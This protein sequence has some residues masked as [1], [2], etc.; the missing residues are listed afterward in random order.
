MRVWLAGVA[1]CL[2][3]CGGADDKGDDTANLGDDLPETIVPTGDEFLVV[4]LPDTQ[5]YAMTYPETFDSQMR[6]IAEHAEAYN[7]VFVSH[8]GDI[9]HNG[10][11]R[12]EWDVAEA[13]YQWIEDIGLPHGFSVGGHDFWV[14]GEEHDSSCA[15]VPWMD[16]DFTDFNESFGPDRYADRA[17][18]GGASPSGRSSYQKV[19][20]AGLDL[21]FLHLPQDTPRAEVEWAG[22]VLDANPGTL[23]HLTTHRYLYDYRLTDLLPEPLNLAPAGRFN[24]LTYTLGGQSLLFNDS[25]SADELFEEFI[26]THPNIWGV[27]CGHV[28]AEF[29]QTETNAAGLPV[30]QMLADFQNMEDGGGGWLR[31]LKFQPADNEVEVFTLST[32]TGE[33]RQ[34]GDGFEHSLTIVEDYKDLAFAELAALGFD[35]QAIED[36]LDEVKTEGSKLRDAYYESLYGAGDRDSRFTLEVPFSDYVDASK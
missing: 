29:R 27:H 10:D 24:A 17:W 13:S 5:I 8:V 25:L 23:V 9:V 35:T 34:N 3:G 36:L 20:S 19:S 14:G 28:D 21:L 16:C 15:V 12:N 4:V 18:F 22:E 1:L 26:E 2:V 33:F 31:V 11:R 32:L 6:W 30:H 7:I